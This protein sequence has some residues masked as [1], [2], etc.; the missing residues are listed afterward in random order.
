MQLNH[1]AKSDLHGHVEVRISVFGTH[2]KA[3][4]WFQSSFASIARQDF[5]SECLTVDPAHQVRGWRLNDS[6]HLDV[7]SHLQFWH[8]DHFL[9][10]R[11]NELLWN[12]GLSLC[13]SQFSKFSCF[14]N[15]GIQTA[16]CHPV[17]VV[18]APVDGS[19]RC[20]WH[21]IDRRWLIFGAEWSQDSLH[22]WWAGTFWKLSGDNQLCTLSNPPTPPHQP[23]PASTP[24]VHKLFFWEGSNNWFAVAW[25]CTSYF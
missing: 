10:M 5:Q 16:V 23:V 8:P 19:E 15:T 13:R 14:A 18:Q 22:L 4:S 20:W 7:S 24:R 2:G 12:D 17:N 11:W 6:F 9:D 3:S 25:W 21:V 1:A